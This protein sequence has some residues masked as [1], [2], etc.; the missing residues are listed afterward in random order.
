[1][2]IRDRSGPTETDG[3]GILPVKRYRISYCG[4][5]LLFTGTIPPGVLECILARLLQTEWALGCLPERTFRHLTI[6]LTRR[7]AEGYNKFQIGYRLN[8]NMR[9][10]KIKW[11][12]SGPVSYTHLLKGGTRKY[13]CFFKNHRR[14]AN[15]RRILWNPRTNIFLFLQNSRLIGSQ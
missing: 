15:T 3:G 6:L 4:W 7:M 5:R 12:R 11:K 1:M 2:C 13:D 9:G 8:R 10:I 14:G